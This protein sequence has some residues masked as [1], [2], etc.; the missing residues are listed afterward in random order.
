MKQAQGVALRRRVAAVA[1][2][3]S[4][5]F[6]LAQAQSEGRDSTGK[7]TVGV[8]LGGVTVTAT[9]TGQ[10]AL[11]MPGHVTVVTRV[12]IQGSAAQTLGDFL[13]TIPG[14][15]M[16]DYQGTIAAHPT[17]QAA[18]LRGLGGGTAAGRTLILMD[19]VPI[20]D[21]FAGWT[22]WSRVPLDLVERIEVVRGGGS[23][24]WGSRAMGGVIN[25]ITRAPS[26]TGGQVTA[27]GGSLGTGRGNV[28]ATYLGSRL[29]LVASGDYL[30]SD[31]FVGVRASQRGAIDKAAGTTAGTAYARADL[32]VSSTLT[33]NGAVQW[34]D[35]SRDWGSALRTSG[36]QLGFA[37]AGARWLPR[38]GH[39]L[40][41]DAFAT[42]QTA[43]S[44][45]TT[46]TLDR[47]REDR[48]LDQFDVP[49]TATGV[50]LQWSSRAS[51]RHELT[52]GGDWF[53]VDGEANEDFLLVQNSFTRRRNVGGTQV[54]Q[55]VYAQEVLKPS[56][57]WRLLGA[58]RW[59]AARTSDGFRHEWALAPGIRSIDSTYRTIDERTLN[60]S[61]GVR[62]ELTPAL[63]W[64]ANAFRAYRAPTLNELYKGFREPG[65]VIAEA[66]SRLSSEHVTGA[67]LGADLTLGT[68]LLARVTAFTSQVRD[69]IVEVTIGTAGATGR[70][71][72]PCGFVPA[73]GTC[74]QRQNL[75]RFRAA[76]METELEWRIDRAW[77]LAGSYLFNPTEVTR[78]PNNPELVG[79]EGSRTPRHSLTTTLR[80]DDPA[81]VDAAVTGRYIGSRF[82]DDL[83]QF[84]L[85]SFFLVDAR[86]ARRITAGWTA[87][88][89]VE[90]VAD[91]EFITAIPSSG[92]QRVGAPRTF[93]AGTR[94]QW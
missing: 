83:N 21:P 36:M 74:R 88:V 14:F 42:D 47:T 44:T 93:I 13:R 40:R 27:Q 28:T 81:V 19:G 68:R 76:G 25:I 29:G 39:E 17:R 48:S 78:A 71:I 1:C 89:T 26:R 18:S 94:V 12:Q 24:I 63:A 60:F 65:N 58:V 23:G 92:L 55:G 20:V 37:R 9:R 52:V 77:Q 82:E 50:T 49:A 41:L 30:S 10:P 67:E 43:R 72:V 64:R 33:L 80:F 3:L 34:L 57:R 32:H 53:R 79:N 84:R 22:Y 75:E 62:H 38:D 70:P 66:N 86:L 73:G 16:R 35:E 46:E 4:S 15:T 2:M 59:D 45:F 31:G 91:R 85:P 90:N 5:P 69:P 11:E 6:P 54:L 51:A 8:A 87:F 56:D 7:D 61:V